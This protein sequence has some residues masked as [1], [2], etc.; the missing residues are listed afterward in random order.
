MAVASWTY[1]ALPADVRNE[2]P[3]AD[4]LTPALDWSEDKER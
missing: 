2:L 4:K 1:D 3:D